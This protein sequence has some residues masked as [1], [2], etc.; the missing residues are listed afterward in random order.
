MTVDQF[1]KLK[2]RYNNYKNKILPFWEQLNLPE[3]EN[4]ELT[5]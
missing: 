5:L 2:K 4:T 1:P 3:K